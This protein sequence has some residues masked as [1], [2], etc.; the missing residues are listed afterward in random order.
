[1]LALWASILCKHQV[2]L[3]QTYMYHLAQ[4]HAHN[5]TRSLTDDTS[6]KHT[7]MCGSMPH[8]LQRDSYL[9]CRRSL[10]STERLVACTLTNPASARALH[11]LQSLQIPPSLLRSR[12]PISNKYSCS[13]PSYKIL[14]CGDV[15]TR[16]CSMCMVNRT[17][18]DTLHEITSK[19]AGLHETP[20]WIQQFMQCQTC[21]A[22]GS[23]Q[24]LEIT[25]S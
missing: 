9:C 16:C 20:T 13:P 1:M 15:W 6:S 2:K 5:N 17:L 11:T 19:C 7:N 8:F 23:I 14:S 3:Q 18:I 24:R 25:G 21:W 4:H 22:L 10:A 12:A